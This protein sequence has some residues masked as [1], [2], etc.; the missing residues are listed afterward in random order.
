METC[1]SPAADVPPPRE[2]LPFTF[3]AGFRAQANL[4]FVAVYVAEEQGFFNS[5]GLDVTIQHSAGQSEHVRLLLAGKVDVTT[6]PASELLERRADPGAPLVAVALFGQTG[7][8][9]YA[10]LADRD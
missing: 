2:R 6:Q 4:P 3:M 7:D 9:G 8:L 10:L 1:S 5:V